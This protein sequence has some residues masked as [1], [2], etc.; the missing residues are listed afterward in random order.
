MLQNFPLIWVDSSTF[1][2]QISNSKL[3]LSNLS[4]EIKEFES[5]SKSKLTFYFPILIKDYK[6][7]Y[8]FCSSHEKSICFTVDIKNLKLIPEGNYRKYKLKKDFFI[9]TVF[10]DSLQNYF[11]CQDSL[12]Y[13]IQGNV[14]Y[15]A[16]N[17]HLAILDRNKQEKFISLIV[18]NNDKKLIL[19]ENLNENN[20]LVAIIDEE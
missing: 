9:K 17:S 8:L 18:W 13:A 19:K 20:Y 5:L 10:T 11:Y 4:G 6:D 3:A 12:I 15:T 16:S 14:E 1:L 2:F 7:D